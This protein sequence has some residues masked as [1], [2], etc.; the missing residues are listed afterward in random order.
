[1][2]IHEW[3]PIVVPGLQQT[4]DYAQSVFSA[5][6]PFLGTDELEQKVKERMDRQQIFH[7]P[8][9][10]PKLWEVIPE[11]ALRHVIGSAEIMRA[12]LDKLIEAAVSTDVVLQV[13]PYS[14]H[15]NPGTNGPIL[16]FD[17]AKDPSIVYTECDGGGML[18]ESPELVTAL[19]TK[20]NLIRAAALSPRES[21]RLLRNIRDEMA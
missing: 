4:E 1:M 19:S 6:Y 21:L 7:R 12:Q 18:V 10:C 20:M 13:L 14:A 8:V 9:G 15:E 16:I 5:A 3:S 2:R 11:S 17:F